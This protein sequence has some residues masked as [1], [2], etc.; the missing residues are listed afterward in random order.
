MKVLLVR[1]WVNK[2]ITTVKN[3]LFG[4]PMGIECVSTIL[5]ENNTEVLLVDFMVETNGRLETYLENF[6]PDIVGVTSQCTDVE[7]VVQIAKMTK[8]FNEGITVLVGGVQAATYP[9]SFF[10][11][12]IDYVFK[13]TTRKNIKELIQNVANGNEP[14]LIDGVYSKNLQFKN[15]GEFCF[16]EYIV[17][18]R[19]STARYRKEY[20]Y[21][22]YKPCAVLQ[23]AYGCRNRC[24]F[25]VRWKLEGSMVREIP[26]DEIAD[27][28]ESIDEPY[29]MICDNDFLINEKRLIRFCE[30]LEER[31][32]KKEYMCYG[33]VNSI[34]EKS[35][36]LDRLRKNGIV[37]VIVGYEAFDN[38]RLKSYNKAATVDDNITATELLRKSNIACWGS[39]IIHPD[40]EKSDFKKLIEYINILK[41]ELITFS[42]LVPH[43]L[44]PLY[45]EFKDR[46]IYEKEDYD[47]W[48]FGDVLIYPS[49]ISLKAYYWEVL[50]LTLKVNGNRHSVKYTLKTF[51]IKNT[52]KMVFG[53]NS[54]FK[55]YIKNF[56]TRR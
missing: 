12:C 45:D 51:P 54:L 44:T 31:N 50:K 46:L 3:F 11:D 25:C 20:S 6:K 35:D 19:E 37:A 33:S 52:L 36:V 41:P 28:I 39:F 15:D 8:Q 21:I 53:F 49:K 18:D 2:N 5:K 24:N 4:E 29:I 16:N 14:V 55:V 43:P 23:T 42:P 1:P 22:G 48:N 38:N 32:I 7:N 30:L 34:L 13:S 17:P 9:D 47:K 27:Q 10:L 26:I 56:L 40:W